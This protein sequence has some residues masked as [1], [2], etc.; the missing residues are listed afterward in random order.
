MLQACGV[1]LG[2]LVANTKGS[3]G[4]SAVRACRRAAS[5]KPFLCL[6]QRCAKGLGAAGHP[7]ASAAHDGVEGSKVQCL[8]GRRAGMVEKIR[9]MVFP[10]P[11]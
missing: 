11:C 4:P 9:R 1:F 6:M 2:L 10:C 3:D 7:D 8:M 5:V